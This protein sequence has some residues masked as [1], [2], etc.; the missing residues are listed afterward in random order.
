MFDLFRSREK[1]VRILL[2]ALLVLV[3]LSMLTYLIPSYNQGGA[4]TNGSVVAT[5]AGTEITS[6]D[7]QKLIQAAMR[8]K[9][10]PAE[11]LPNYIPSMVDEMVTQRAM[12]YEAT[13]LGLEVTNQDMADTMRQIYPNLFPDGKFIGKQAYAAML[14]QQQMDIEEFEN[15]LRRELLVSRLRDIALEGTIVTPLEIEETYKKRNEKVKIEF[16]KLNSDKYKNEIHPTDQ[17]LQG[18]FHA[19]AAT[20][21]VPE[22]RNLTIL[23]A[24]QAKMM[25][26]I[27]PTDAEL[28]MEYTRNR[29]TYRTPEQA[30]VR[31]ILLK[32]IGKTPAED[33]KIKAQAD[34]LLKQVR[35]G[36]NFADLVKKYSEDTASVKDGGEYT[37]QKNGQMVPEFEKAAFTLKPGESDVIK[38]A[39]GYHIIQVMKHEDA[40]LR[41]FDE[42]KGEI[43]QK[44]K[45]QRVS[46]VMQQISDK[47]QQELQKDPTHPEKVAAEYNMQI[48]PA[49][50]FESGKP[51]PEIG[52]NN[53][54]DQS[55]AG[56]KKGDVSQPVAVPGNKIVLAV[57][58]DV[59]PARPATFDEVKDKV[60]DAVIQGRLLKAVQDH[61][62]EL[63][64]KAKSMGDLGKAAKSMGLEM[65]TSDEFTRT[66]TVEG[67]GMASYFSEA[68]SDPVGTVFGPIL[69]PGDTI[70]AKV[71]AHT[72]AD[73]SKLPEQRAQ[74]RDDLK[75]QKG[76]DRNSLFEAGLRD[77]L[78]KQGKIKI[79]QEIIQR[80]IANYRTNG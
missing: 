73:M 69:M 68:F 40:R 76:R 47:A 25:Q 38:T 49:N 45:Q 71:V 26:G 60:R 39:Y 11:L 19:N 15:N 35:G 18:Y 42:V 79:N 37:I 23:L 57:V 8:N 28:Q 14:A 55:V 27:N 44:L 51:A 52:V 5:V 56:L 64:D 2:G 53:D 21:Q 67:A 12:E 70:V 32:T 62:K 80:I 63:V 6:L 24:D 22:K 65:K 10:F 58:T 54:F 29:E 59:V 31:H 17:D 43:A 48:V 61:A 75:Q 7:V 13:R 50:G 41:T 3:A 34:D 77:Q 78:I 66:G 46:N 20:Y 74:I 36:A 4:V 33:A 72:P 9:Q 16:V 30:K 1:S